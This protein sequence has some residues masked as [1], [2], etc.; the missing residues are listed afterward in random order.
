MASAETSS[1]FGNNTNLTTFNLSARNKAAE[2]II[3]DYAAGHVA[4]DIAIGAAGFLPIP[5][6]GTMGLLA[7]IAAQVPL[8]YQPMARQLGVVY[9][10]E[11]DD[12]TKGMNIET[13]VLVGKFDMAVAFGTD[14][15]AEI[16]KELLPELGLGGLLSAVPF[17]GGIAAAALDA[18]VAAT[19]TWRV[20]TMV[21]IYYQN[22]E[23]WIDDRRTTYHR[24]KGMVGGLSP[25]TE[26]RVVLDDIPSTNPEVMLK[27]I[28]FVENLIQTLRVVTEDKAMIRKAL[29]A[30][31]IPVPLIDAALKHY[32]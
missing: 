5:G 3:K 28:A 24:A 11:P 32:A 4:L 15:M 21:A 20:G 27:Q 31:H 22:S 17:I 12:V 7:S 10:A 1:S 16:A 29:L 23:N 19:L 6:I 30:K 14:F 25:K 9:S 13:A 18:T 8:V 26:G 2:K